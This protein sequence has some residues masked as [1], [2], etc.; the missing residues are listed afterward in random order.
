[1]KATPGDMQAFLDECQLPTFSQTE[2]D[3]LGAEITC[4]EIM[5]SIKSLKNGKSPGPDGFGNEFYKKFSDLLVPHLN[6]M[7]GQAFD[8][9]ELPHTLN[10]AI[11]TLIP[12]IGN[13]LEE[14]GSY[15][16][17]S[18]LKTDQKIL[19]KTLAKRLSLLIGK[20]VYPD[21]T[22]FI[23]QRYSYFNLRRLFNVMYSSRHQGGPFGTI[24][25]CRKGI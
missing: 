16:P 5:E 25:R 15:R 24:F 8:N 19:T 6:K 4:E 13:D 22:G 18:L 12:K 7:F 10:E 20:L 23:P 3:Y 14:V 21:Q 1:M 11:I 2:R 17:I 9:G